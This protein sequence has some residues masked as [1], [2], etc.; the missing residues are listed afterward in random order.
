VVILADLSNRC[1]DG[2][3][4]VPVFKCAADY[5]AGYKTLSPDIE[6]RLM[7]ALTQTKMAAQCG[8]FDRC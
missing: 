6:T 5:A 2:W 3:K 1:K 8:H 7:R 4:N